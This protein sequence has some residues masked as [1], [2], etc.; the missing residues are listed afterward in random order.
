MKYTAKDVYRTGNQFYAASVALNEKLS[1]TNDIG[2]YIA[3]IIT[4]MINK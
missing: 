1:E 4:N 3:P 2:L